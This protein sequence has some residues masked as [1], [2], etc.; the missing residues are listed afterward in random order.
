M[1]KT[2]INIEYQHLKALDSLSEQTKPNISKAAREFGVLDSR[3][4][5]RWKGGKSLFQRPLNGRKLSPI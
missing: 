5:R 3:L 2:N 1:F 4:R